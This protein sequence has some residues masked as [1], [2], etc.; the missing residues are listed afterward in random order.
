MSPWVAATSVL[1]GCGGIG[2]GPPVGAVVVV[3]GGS[4]GCAAAAWA[5][6]F[7]VALELENPPDA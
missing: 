7:G 4:A 3:V 5:W 6:W 2:G 1:A